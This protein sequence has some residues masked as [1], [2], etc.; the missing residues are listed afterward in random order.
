MPP[1][2]V[3][4]VQC[5]CCRARKTTLPP[6]LWPSVR[7]GVPHLISDR[8]FR[9]RA[10]CINNKTSYHQGHNQ[11]RKRRSCSFLTTL[12]LLKPWGAVCV[13]YRAV[14][15]GRLNTVFYV[16]VLCFTPFYAFLVPHRF[17]RFTPTKGSVIES[18]RLRSKKKR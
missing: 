8:L 14:E 6:R 10:R 2:Y 5:G 11:L 17:S 12:A 13:R 3:P 18:G 16:Y 7:D 9:V 1:S 4:S 15:S